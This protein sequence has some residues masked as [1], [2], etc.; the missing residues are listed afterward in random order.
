MQQNTHAQSTKNAN[1]ALSIILHAHSKQTPLLEQR[2]HVSEHT[3][4][5]SGIYSGTYRILRRHVS[6]FIPAHIGNYLSGQFDLYTNILLPTRL[7][8]YI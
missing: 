3:P 1:S 2:R 5:R 4:I 7:K 8:L 6:A